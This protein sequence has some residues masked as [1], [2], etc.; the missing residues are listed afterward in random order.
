VI[1]EDMGAK[2]VVTVG[3]DGKV[4]EDVTHQK[5]EWGLKWK[6]QKSRYTS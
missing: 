2:E 1:K 6:D 3:W 5:G 4:I